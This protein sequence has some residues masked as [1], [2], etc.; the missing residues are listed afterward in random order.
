MG[1]T[2]WETGYKCVGGSWLVSHLGRNVKFS[3]MLKGQEIAVL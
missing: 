1:N 3:K 2:I